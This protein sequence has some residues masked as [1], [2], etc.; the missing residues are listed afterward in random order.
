M[1]EIEVNGARL[2]YV[3]EGE[4]K[5]L[6][7]VHGSISDYRSWN[8]QVA[9]FAHYYHVVAYSRRYH[10]PHPWPGSGPEFAAELHAEDLAGLLARLALEPANLVGSSYGALT[11]LICA[12][13][14]P[15]AVRSLVLAEP[16]ILPWL[17]RIEG[18]KPLLDA[19]MNSAWHPAT[20]AFA[21]GDPVAGVRAFVNGISGAPVFDQIP[22]PVRA[23]QIDNG[24]ALHAETVARPESY[25]STLT[26]EE[27]A[28]VTVPTLLL[29]GER[30]PLMFGLV[31]DELARC[32]PNP[33]RATILAASHSMASGNP[34]AF[35]DAVLSFLRGQQEGC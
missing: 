5:P 17:N 27:V 35:N 21:S 3:E 30:S 10:Y 33:Q 11:S 28:G 24:P 13:R 26:C 31:L 19:F 2:T 8:A 29:R 20:Q 32:L 9:F 16:P 15:G 12:I 14:Y 1:P 18:G 23:V 6:V 34:P 22:E 7:F 25:F 4:G